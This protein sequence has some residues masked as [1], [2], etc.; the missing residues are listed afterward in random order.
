MA[1]NKLKSRLNFYSFTITLIWFVLVAASFSWTIFHHKQEIKNI[2]I[3]EAKA[4]LSWDE[5]LRLWAASHGGV[6]APKTS[7]TPPNP[8]LGF[9]PEREVQTPSGVILTLMNPTYIVR[10]LTEDFSDKN[11]TITHITSIDPMNPEN[12]PDQWEESALIDFT[13]GVHEK[14]AF[15][16]IDN[17]PYVRLMR[18]KILTTECLQ[19]HG[20]QGYKVGDLYGGISISLPMT[21]LLSHLD[22]HKQIM[23]IGFGLLLASGIIGILWTRNRIL[24]D[25]EERDR[26]EAKLRESEEE[27]KTVSD[28]SYAWE[29]WINPDGSLRYVSPSC[30]RISGY[31]P[32]Q[33]LNDP[34]F[35]Q[36]IIYP[37][38]ITTFQD[39][40]SD[41]LKSEHVCKKNYRIVT[42]SGEIRWI[43]HICQPVYNENGEYLGRRA[44]NYN[45][46]QR[47]TA[48]EEKEKLIR[49]L[50]SALEKVKVLS[51][52][53]PICSSCKKIRDDKGYWNQIEQY[54]SK[55]SDAEFSH[56]IC[57]ECAKKLYPDF[58]YKK[59]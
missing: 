35:L 57:P 38:D 26:M 22:T 33:F 1:K 13:Q 6:Y 10:Q 12:T 2:A 28:F 4:F 48:E 17:T 14:I 11:G 7:H 54:I 16:D 58:N 42:K 9:I 36:S 29:Y 47:K 34:Q 39:H 45:I 8:F 27:F 32:E 3:A 5:A 23:L 19:C 18:P 20:I 40:I 59:K 50:Q 15:V 24:A 44:S 56:G 55:H 49:E 25:I 52:F 41:E 51:G 43:N 31:G 37:E 53:L 30:L 21:R 46:T